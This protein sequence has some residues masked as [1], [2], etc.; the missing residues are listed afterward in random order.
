MKP[1]RILISDID[2]TLLN[3]GKET[4]G[5]DTLR[6]L[7]ARHKNDV[8]LVYATGRSHD[9]VW[10]LIR[11]DILPIP[12]AIAA[13]IGTEIWFPNWKQSDK[14]FKSL[15]G[16][17]WNR[18]TILNAALTIPGLRLQDEEMQ[19]PYKVSF[20]VSSHRKVMDI[21]SLLKTKGLAVRIIYSCGKYLDVLPARGGK[22]A[23]VKFLSQVWEVP[24]KNILTSGDSGND[25]DMLT[26][27]ETANVLVAN[28]ESEM[29]SLVKT[30][31]VYHADGSYAA[32]VVEGC[33]AFGF[34]PQAS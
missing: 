17:D 8:A 30:N 15:I 6:D 5:L 14:R 32:G 18:E 33:R 24:F 11:A 26:H 25:M 20:E 12:D 16:N 27:P 23:A 22:M 10:D 3:N 19:T 29:A 13:S 31:C 4:R 2:G 28:A 7:L 34:W 9:S 1:N 21:Q